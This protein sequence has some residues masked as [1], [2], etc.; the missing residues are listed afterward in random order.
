[1]MP[2]IFVGGTPVP[3]EAPPAEALED[4]T[5]GYVPWSIS[6]MVPCAPSN[7]MRLPWAMALFEQN[8]GIADHGPDF[9]GVLLILRADFARNRWCRAD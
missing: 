5:N 6:S 3:M 7:R 2:S 9:F 4:V 8:S 1:M